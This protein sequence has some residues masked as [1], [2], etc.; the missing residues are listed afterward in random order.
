MWLLRSKIHKLLNIRVYLNKPQIPY[1]KYVSNVEF[2]M[3]RRDCAKTIT[4]L[5]P[6]H[7][8]N[9]PLHVM[10]VPSHM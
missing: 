7:R 2:S 9:L 5:T 3:E 1:L 10:I 6:T 8:L 4:L